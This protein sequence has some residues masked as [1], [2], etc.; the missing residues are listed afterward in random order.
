[1]AGAGEPAGEET[2]GAE[3][4]G[5][6]AEGPGMG[7]AAAGVGDAFGWRNKEIRVRPR[8]RDGKKERNT[9]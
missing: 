8:K 5:R 3:A 2:A 6:K 7:E 1:M 4:T 9:D